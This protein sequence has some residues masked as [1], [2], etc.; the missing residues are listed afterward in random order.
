MAEPPSK[1]DTM[2]WDSIYPFAVSKLGIRP[3][4]FWGMTFGEYWPLFNIMTGRTVKPLSRDELEKLE[5]A[6]AGD[7]DT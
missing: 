4:E 5:R 7:G 3:N 1:K 2:P 6:W